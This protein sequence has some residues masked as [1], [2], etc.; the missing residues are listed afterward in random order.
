MAD[1]ELGKRRVTNA[2]YVLGE[3]SSHVALFHPLQ[4]LPLLPRCTCW[5]SL[6]IRPHHGSVQQETA[7]IPLL[8][9]RHRSLQ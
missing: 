1:A 6:H 7:F 3:L 5:A 4:A 2:P 8:P 9:D